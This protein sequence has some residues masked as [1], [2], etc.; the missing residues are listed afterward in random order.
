MWGTGGSHWRW[1][2][3]TSM[4]LG[5]SIGHAFGSITSK[6]EQSKRAAVR[7]TLK[8]WHGSMKIQRRYSTPGFWSMSG[9][10]TP[11]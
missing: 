4:W 9:Y 8:Y 6:Q 5:T 11:T 2:S 1:C 7:L 10:A 3:W